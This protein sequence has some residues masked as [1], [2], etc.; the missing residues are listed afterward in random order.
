[1][2]RRESVVVEVIVKRLIL[3]REGALLAVA[4]LLMISDILFLKDWRLCLE[5]KVN[6][7]KK[8]DKGSKGEQTASA[9]VIVAVAG[10]NQLGIS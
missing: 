2:T 5:D 1:M 3:W 6:E 4:F 8:E 7:E 9:E 10:G